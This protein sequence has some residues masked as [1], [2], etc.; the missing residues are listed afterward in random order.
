MKKF[1]ATLTLLLVLGVPLAIANIR[2]LYSWFP[3]LKPAIANAIDVVTGYVPPSGPSLV[4]RGPKFK[5]EYRSYAEERQIQ[6]GR[7]ICPTEPVG[8]MRLTIQSM[9]DDPIQVK[10][11][12]VNE[13]ADC[14][15]DPLPK[16]R[17]AQKAAGGDVE[18]LDRIIARET[19]RVAT[20]KFGDKTTVRY[21]D[22][23]P[24]RVRI[25]TDRGEAVYDLE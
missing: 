8:V 7:N 11:V 13:N 12:V 22:C 25:I 4:S 15:A 10:D 3:A 1:G 9:N 2:T 23:D 18:A 21:L 5:V 14:T 24:I 19:P 20:M 6:C 16:L 17:A